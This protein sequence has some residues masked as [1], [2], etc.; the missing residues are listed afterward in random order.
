[1]TTTLQLTGRQP[2]KLT[3]L[4]L[5]TCT[6][7]VGYV[8]SIDEG[9]WSE[10]RSQGTTLSSVQYEMITSNDLAHRPIVWPRLA[11][12]KQ[13]QSEQESNE[14]DDIVSRPQPSQTHSK[15]V[16][17]DHLDTNHSPRLPQ[18]GLYEYVDDPEH[19]HLRPITFEDKR[20]DFND[21]YCAQSS[22]PQNILPSK[23]GPYDYDDIYPSKH[24]KNDSPHGCPK[25][26]N[27]TMPFQPSV[28]NPLQISPHYYDGTFQHPR[29][30]D[31]GFGG[32]EYDPMNILRSIEP[33]NQKH[34]NAQVTLYVLYIH[35]NCVT[36]RGV[37]NFI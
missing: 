5:C 13:H 18:T 16:T 6:D 3:F 35:C 20:Y 37:N 23:L 14:Y 1:M 24:L 2:N 29:P 22:Q 34:S 26:S 27:S 30:K 33:A 11:P 7:N 19:Q 12:Y 4:F 15:P 31:F 21:E 36:F 32:Y 10:N 28:S 25:Q 9:E 17:T 8:G